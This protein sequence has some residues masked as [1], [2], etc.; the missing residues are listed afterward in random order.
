MKDTINISTFAKNVRAKCII[1]SKYQTGKMIVSAELSRYV[2]EKKRIRRNNRIHELE[3]KIN[4]N[5]DEEKEIRLIYLIN[6]FK[7]KN[8]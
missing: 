8:T 2:C 5:R 7:R 3:N 6:P 1:F 4:L